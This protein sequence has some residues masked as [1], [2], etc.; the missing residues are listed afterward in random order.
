MDD[1]V[2]VTVR[3]EDQDLTV[4]LVPAESGWHVLVALTEDSDEITLTDDE[5]IE[6]IR[7]ADDGLDETGLE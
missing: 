7:L 1:Q 3:R 2:T 6:A 5:R 4:A